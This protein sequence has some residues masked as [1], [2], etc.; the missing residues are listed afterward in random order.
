MTAKPIVSI[1]SI[2][3]A[4]LMPSGSYGSLP[5]VPP[6]FKASNG[7]RIIPELKITSFVK[8]DVSYEQPSLWIGNKRI[9]FREFFNH[10][11]DQM[12]VIVVDNQAILGLHFWGV[13][14]DKMFGFPFKAKEG[15]TPQLKTDKAAN[16]ITYSKQYVQL[17][18]ETATF[19]YTLKPAGESKVEVS[20][21]IGIPQERIDAT[22]KAFAYVS[23][24]FTSNNSYR[25]APVVINGQVIKINEKSVFEKK[26]AP[27]TNGTVLEFVYN[28]GKPL[29]S[30]CFKLP[31]HYSFS[32]SEG[33]RGG[34]CELF[35][36]TNSKKTL[37]GD[38]FIIDFGDA[39]QNAPGAPAPVAGID[40]WG[41]DRMGVPPPTTRNL[42][43]NPSFE[44][45]LRFWTWW[46]GGGSF[47]LSDIPQ[48]SISSDAVFGGKSLLIRP[49]QG[50]QPMNSF[51][52]PVLKDKTYTLSFYAKSDKPGARLTFGVLGTKGSK[53][54]WMEAF[55]SQFPLSGGWERKSFSFTP[56]CRG[57]SFLV[58][59]AS[60]VLIDG[61]QLEA[62][63]APSEFVSPEVEGMLI[64]S[65]PDNN[66]AAG[67]PVNAAFEICGKP[68]A[69][70]EV[71]LNLFN[72][73]REKLYTFKSPYILND[74]GFAKLPLPF[75]DSRLETGVF[76]IQSEI[77]PEKGVPVRDY[78]RLSIMDFLENKHP[79]KDLFG[80]LC[81]AT[82]ITRADDL[83]RNYMRWGFGSI[84]YGEAKEQ[85]AQLLRKYRITNYLMVISN[86]VNAEERPVVKDALEKW[87]E[88][89]PEREKQLEDIAFNIVK[90][91]PWGTSWAFSTEVEGRSPLT[92]A[93]KFD[94]WAKVQMA[95]SR[96]IRK[97][98]PD[99]VSLPEGGTSGF[100]RLRGYRETEGYLAATAGK[101]KW[102][103]IAT[104]PYG[105]I[106]DLDIV[107]DMMIGLTAKYG[108]KEIPIDYTEG[109]NVTHTK[110]PE[111]GDDGC[112]DNYQ[113]GKPSY[114]FGWREYL[115]AAWIARTYITCMK[116]WPRVRSFNI[117]TAHPYM[118]QYLT[119]LAACKVPNTLGHLLGNPK[120][121]ADIRPAAGV[122]GYVFED[123]QGRGVAAVWCSI[124][125][126]EE[127]IERG[128]ELFVKFED[129]I[130]EFIDLMGNKRT[131]AV[132]KGIASIPLNSA[133]LF[134]RS[135]RGGADKLAGALNN[136]DVSGA[137]SSLMVVIQPDTNGSIEAITNN[138]TGKDLRGTLKIGENSIPFAIPAKSNVVNKLKESVEPVPGK[139][140]DWK[141][142]I[143]IEFPGGRKDS[144][145]WDM[146]FLY[147]PHTDKP[148]PLDPLAPEWNKIPSIRMNNWF[149]QK[150]SGVKPVDGGYP[151]DLDAGFQIAW[152]KNN[153]YL[154]IECKDDKFILTGPAR[155]RKSINGS[156][157]ML[158]MNDGCVELYLDTGANGRSNTFKGFDQDDYRYD[159]YAGSAAAT[160][161][162]GTVYRLREVYHQLA[163]GIIMATKDEAAK[164]VKCQFHRDGNNYSYVIIL[165]QWYIEPL[166][167]E[168]GWR[169]GF[170]L[171]IHDNDDPAR[172]WPG[173]GLSLATEPGAHCDR[174][175]DLWPVMVLE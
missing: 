148:L 10:E 84:T 143:G 54:S 161:G 24:W 51:M 99:A 127:G 19:S 67:Q 16:T 21:N 66:L 71:E 91:H 68:N 75:E 100:S 6:P 4:L 12:A 112:Y 2:T 141:G 46:G 53:F 59:S 42:M 81:S 36:P 34:G 37:A 93:G 106:D 15:T 35:I 132:E 14:G 144:S 30:F 88:I 58:C 136:A 156:D 146:Q 154:R 124:S 163:G 94:E 170:G 145:R 142:D 70:G 120:F 105:A 95:V 167:L 72:Y 135:K 147:V 41:Q 102:D 157:P 125:K 104:H 63:S 113:G 89:T 62:G 52:I 1:L 96:G 107:S 61:I 134:I 97:A 55:K 49:T 175:P 25:L 122:R 172:D 9:G 140:H 50:G 128:P 171:Y 82:R 44:Q 69:K 83:A 32:A 158:Y 57:I 126:V 13:N 45:G 174:R 101:I 129:D 43:P 74:R 123:E 20:W 165:P 117:W 133:P 5:D 23:P 26:S 56:D 27:L 155:R 7:K 3:M 119:P 139:L 169:A 73:Y 153:L 11:R 48:Y 131:P 160:D 166:K 33:A 109:F 151:G 80:N 121:T 159:F 64:S 118:D 164:G 152:D 17:N 28:P 87:T 65:D 150:S 76:V 114:D 98:K 149:I 130:P 90:R 8:G 79:S 108:Y 110:I 29:E 22:P 85:E 138:L 40:F 168:K 111:W 39:A 78:Y 60:T 162:P 18:G 77:R 103:A 137:A 47:V 86:Y 31:D 115:H 116:Y 92:R 173:K 38:S